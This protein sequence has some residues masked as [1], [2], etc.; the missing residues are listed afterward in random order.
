MQIKEKFSAISVIDVTLTTSWLEF[1]AVVKDPACCSL[2]AES[3]DDLD[4]GE[5]MTFL[6][7]KSF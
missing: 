3:I 2:V 1:K 4:E 6:I 5:N 7:I